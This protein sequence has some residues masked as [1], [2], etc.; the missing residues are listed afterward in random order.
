MTKAQKAIVGAAISLFVV[1][2][3][4]APWRMEVPQGRS[5][6]RKAPIWSP[7]DSLQISVRLDLG[8]LSAQWIGIA[9]VGGLA[10]LVARPRSVNPSAG[11]G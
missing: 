7:P 9:V 3:V 6:V 8:L 5:F 2:L 1:S 10:F 4:F 11:L